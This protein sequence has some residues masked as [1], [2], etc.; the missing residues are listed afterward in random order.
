MSNKRAWS[1]EFNSLKDFIELL[2]IPS[3]ASGMFGRTAATTIIELEAERDALQA[4]LGEAID[5][6]KDILKQDDGQ[7]YKEAEKFLD[8][9]EGEG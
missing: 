8:K 7:A 1:E 3:N 6:I 4:R 2:N 9:L 5:R